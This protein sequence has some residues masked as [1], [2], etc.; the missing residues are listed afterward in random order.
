MEATTT[1]SDNP[2]AHRYEVAVDAQVA[3]YVQYRARPGLIALIHTQID[4]RMA[5]RG[6]GG[7]LIAAVLDDARAKGLAVLP[8]CPFVNAYIKRHP[9]DR[10]LVPRDYWEE[11]DLG[12]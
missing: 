6:L 3:G 10:D 5:G 2:A 8:F 12:A 4:G 9:E 11:F 1:V 7:T